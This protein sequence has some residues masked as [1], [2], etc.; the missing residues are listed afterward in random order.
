VAAKN[1]QHRTGDLANKKGR[2]HHAGRLLIFDALP[3]FSG[4]IRY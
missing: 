4:E 1:R 2:Q 3:D